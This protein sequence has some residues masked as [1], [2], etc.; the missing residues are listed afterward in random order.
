M[1]YRKLKL[2]VTVQCEAHLGVA[3]LLPRGP[4]SAVSLDLTIMK[5]LNNKRLATGGVSRGHPPG[6]ELNDLLY[7]L[8]CAAE[9]IDAE[10]WPEPDTKAAQEAA[11]RYAAKCI[12]E[13]VKR[14]ES[15]RSEKRLDRGHSFK[16]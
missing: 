12:R 16:L 10:E 14:L 3:A 1:F 11:N 7:A 6:F 5:T 2:T 15:K 9:F 13:M 4:V 8:E